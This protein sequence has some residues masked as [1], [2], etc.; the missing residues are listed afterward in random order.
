MTTAA[1]PA[2]AYVRVSTEEQALGGV[3]LDAQVAAV[4]AYAAQHGLHLVDVVVDAGVSGSIPL[5]E[6]AGG[7]VV[8]DLVRRRRVRAVVAAKLDRLFRD[9]ADCLTETAGWNKARVGL[10]L[11]DLAIDTSTTTGRC[12]LTQHAAFAEME[13]GLIRDRTRAALAHKRAQGRRTSHDAPYGFRIAADGDTLVADDH[14]QRVL[15]LVRELRAAGVSIRGIV[16]RLDA[17]GVAA[18]GARWHKT[19][20]ERILRAAA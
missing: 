10:H 14:E 20:I 19:T 12:M 4:R 9:A 2:V 17:D 6:R 5:A 13:R 3:S 11:L 15:G 8:V 7:A 1:T 16:A 18:R